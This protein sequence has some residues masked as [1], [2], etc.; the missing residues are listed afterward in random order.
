MSDNVTSIF[1]G[2][3]ESDSEDQEP[4][5]SIVAFCR[6][7]LSKAEDGTLQNLAVTYLYGDERSPQVARCWI[8]DDFSTMSILH[9]GMAATMHEMQAT[10][11]SA[12]R[13]EDMEDE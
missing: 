6:E 11:L 9:L 8:T 13:Y 10:A 4:N 3:V 5:E 2:P 1:G 12:G 7:L